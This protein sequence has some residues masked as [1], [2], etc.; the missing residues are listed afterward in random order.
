MIRPIYHQFFEALGEGDPNSLARGYLLPNEPFFRPYVAFMSQGGMGWERF[1]EDFGERWNGSPEDVRLLSERMA[2]HDLEAMAGSGYRT[3]TGLLRPSHEPTAYLC[4]G[5][6][7]SNAFMVVVEGEPAVGIGLEAYGRAFGAA[8]M[9]FEDLAHVLPHE[10]CHAVRARETD[11]PLGR[12]FE[13][14]DPATAFDEEPFF[15][16]VAEEG[17]ACLT[18]G[19]A[20]PHLPL[21]R[22]LL[23]APEDLRWCQENEG[24]LLEEFADQ[25]DLPLGGERYE[26]Y[27][28]S[29]LEDDDRPARTG[30]YLGYTLVRRYL[31]EN[32]GVSLAEAVRMPAQ[33]LVG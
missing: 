33:Q 15:E 22:V 14:D 20:A 24:G 18:G 32:P 31:E 17:L 28:G 19:S 2:G 13:S 30:Y 25:R 11:S 6:E 4:V 3:A 16:L 9:G 21:E 29:G 23:Y 7:M 5:L 12:F 1:V 27:F 26:R 8:H 10:L